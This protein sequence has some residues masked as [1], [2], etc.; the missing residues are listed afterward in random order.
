MLTGTYA[1]ART[2][3]SLNDG[4]A[5]RKTNDSV[6]LPVHLPHSWNAED[7]Y[8]SRA[9]YRGKGIYTKDLSIPE[10]LIGK[11]LFLKIDGAASSSEVSLDGQPVGS[12]VGAYSSHTFDITPYIDKKNT[13][14]HSL[15][16]T[17]DNSRK[18]I[19]PYSA[20][21]TFMGGLYR[22][23]WL[24]A[25]DDIH[26][27]FT[28][29]TEEGFS[30]VS[31][32]DGSDNGT[33]KVS[34]DIV[35]ES[36]KNA[37]VNVVVTVSDADGNTLRKEVKK[38]SLRP[39]STVPFVADFRGLKDIALWSP[40]NPELY[41]VSV[42]ILDG[43]KTLD[44][45]AAY[46][47]F[48]TFGF[49]DN[50]S[51]LLNGKP[52]KLRGI[53]R[54]QDRRGAGIALSDEEH[55]RDMLLAKE[56]GA[57]FIRIS[58]YPQDD[59]LLEMCDRLGLIAWEEI[60]VIDFVPDYEGFA[61]NSE[62]MLRDMI[63]RHRNHPSVAMWG[64]MNEILLR[65]PG[66]VKEETWRRTFDLARH[67]ENVVRE[68]DPDRLSAM[69]FHGS[70][71]YHEA[72]LADITDVKGWNLYQGWYGGKFEDFPAFL[73]RQHRQY[74][75]YKIIVSEYGAGS[76]RRLHSFNP[77]AFDFSMEYQQDYLESYLPV[78]ED[79]VFVAGASHW[80]L[81]D[82]SSANRAESM[83]H[84][85]NK[86]ILT[87]SREKKDVFHY[88][89]AMWH[90]SDSDT[91]AHIAVDDWRLRTDLTDADGVVTHPVKVYTN[92][93]EVILSLDGRPLGARRVEN[94]TAIFDVPLHEGKNVLSLCAA[95][96]PARVL[97]AD[98][99]ELDAVRCRDGIID[100]AGDELAVNVGSGCWFRSD[101]TGMTW[102]PDREYA[103]GSGFGY[104]GGEGAVSQ[105]EIALT[106]DGPLLQ[107]CRKGLEEYRFDVAPGLYEVEML[108]SEL[109]SPSEMS[110]YML[111]HNSG[112]G[113]A[114]W[115]CMN[116]G[117]NGTSVE[118]DFAP[119]SEAGVKTMV[120]RRYTAA[121]G[122]DGLRVSLTPADGTTHLSAIKIRRL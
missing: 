39:A 75:D 108:F 118:K 85:N 5:F 27:D 14:G 4:W 12:S 72:Q 53:C 73:S 11:R 18:D 58:H 112:S 22:D 105:D 29:G 107:T 109:A 120:K 78:I 42:E 115:T 91:I 117:I 45:G 121:A 9:Y 10:D 89:A 32:L 7:A 77:K 101:E 93:P 65:V 24:I 17:V 96:D 13:A 34:G 46:T 116:I 106:A 43:E 31:G 79:S 55:R 56:M 15:S 110:A 21:F 25:A 66:K 2:T 68:E 98:V 51:F 38:V 95:S 97:D 16:I 54:H 48:R 88:F 99:V 37:K 103:R 28:S 59:A 35:N 64:Y 60:P 86:G 119:G 50:G 74:P 104:V 47:A 84:I 102:L 61:E 76:D 67:L 36:A 49:D 122:N 90:D 57:N 100:L 63:R 41:R 19:P 44:S 26:L 20:D 23:M 69:A 94:C 40:E 3:R 6:S 71:V 80:N 52:Y 70:D 8:E 81:I 33:L 30:V 114:S 62:T 92:L 111:G 113:N 82:F 87:N 1:S 83:P